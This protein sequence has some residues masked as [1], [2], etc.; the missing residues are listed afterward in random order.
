MTTRPSW[1]WLRLEICSKVKKLLAI[2]LSPLMLQPA[3]FCHSSAAVMIGACSAHRPLNCPCIYRWHSRGAG[4]LHAMR[5]SVG[6]RAQQC[7]GSKKRCGSLIPQP[8]EFQ[9]STHAARPIFCPL[10]MLLPLNR[11]T[12]PSP[13]ACWKLRCLLAPSH[14]L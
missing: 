14:D 5:L 12:S 9:R 6:E 7:E 13:T 4:S 11:R 8:Y 3:P 2:K 1:R 10:A